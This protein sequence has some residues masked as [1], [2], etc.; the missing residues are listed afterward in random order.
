MTAIQEWNQCISPKDPS[1]LQEQAALA[2]YC[3]LPVGNMT[4]DWVLNTADALFARCLRDADHLLW[5]NDPSLPDVAGPAS[6][7]EDSRFLLEQPPMEVSV[8][9]SH[10]NGT[11]VRGNRTCAH[12][13]RTC[14]HGDRTCVRGDRTCVHGNRTCVWGNRTCV[15]VA[16]G[17]LFPSHLLHVASAYNCVAIKK[18]TL[19]KQECRRTGQ[20]IEYGTAPADGEATVQTGLKLASSGLAS[21]NNVKSKVYSMRRG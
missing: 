1:C 11:C 7:P 16:T 17:P 19:D 2:R 18:L 14:V 3:H 13:N 12:G 10:H 21:T 9:L 20:V 5:V 8:M 6:S 15:C 4:G